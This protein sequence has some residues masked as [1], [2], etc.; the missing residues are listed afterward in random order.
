[1]GLLK[2]TAAELLARLPGKPSPGWPDGETF[3]VGLAH[4]TMSVEIYAPVGTDPQ[5]PHAQDELYI[6]LSGRAVF[7]IDGERHAAVPG[8]VLFVGANVEHR[9]V[10][11]TAD[12]TTWVVFWGPAGGE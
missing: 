7:V 12:F 5:T 9:F 6:I 11:F 3:A 1:M 8:T 10:E 4:G 2:A